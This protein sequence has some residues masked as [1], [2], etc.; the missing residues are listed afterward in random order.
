[1][2]KAIRRTFVLLFN[3]STKAIGCLFIVFSKVSCPFRKVE[4]QR[5]HPLVHWDTFS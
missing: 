4:K 3:D 2:K 1:M 5:V